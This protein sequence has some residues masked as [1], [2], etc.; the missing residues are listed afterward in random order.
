MTSSEVKE[1]LRME[2]ADFKE[3]QRGKN[4]PK[5]A[6]ISMGLLQGCLALPAEDLVIAPCICGMFYDNMVSLLA[7][8]LLGFVR[9]PDQE[10][11]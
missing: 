9:S 6:F 8:I 5:E 3:M 2:I 11:S 4:S 7:V 1:I 10:F